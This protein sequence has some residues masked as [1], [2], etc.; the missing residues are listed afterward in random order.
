MAAGNNTP[1]QLYH[2]NTSGSVPTSANLIIGELAINVPDGKIFYKD[3]SN[4]VNVIATTS[5]VLGFFPRIT[6]SGDSTEQYTAAAPY[7]FSNA[8]FLKANSAYAS[9]NVTGTYANAAYAQAN[10]ATTNAATADSKAVAAGSYANAAFTTANNNTASI[11]DLQGVNLTQNTN[12]SNVNT[13]AGKAFDQA[14][15]NTINITNLQGVD[16]TQN[17]GIS[18]AFLQANSA[19]ALANL[20]ST[21]SALDSFARE[22]ATGAFTQANAAFIVANNAVAN[23][24]TITLAGNL[25]VP[26]YAN[27]NQRLAVGTGAYTIL[28]NLIAQ[29]TGTSDYYSQVNQQNLSGKGTADFVATANNGT[30][31]VNYVDMGIAGGNYDNTTPNAFT[32]VQPND[33]YF[34][35]VGNPSQNYGGNVYFGTAG[36]GSFADIVF[37]QG[38]GLNQTARFR[39]NGNV[40]IYRP[41]VANSFTTSSGINVLTYAQDAN[42]YLQGLISQKVS[43]SGDTMTGA[44]T[45]NAS[46]SAN[47]LVI[48]GNVAISQDLRVSGNLYLGGNATTISSNNLTLSDP[49][50]YLADGNPTD[51]VDIGFVGAY[52]DGTYKH[53]GFARDHSDDKWKLF[54]SVTDEPNTTINWAQATYATLKVGGLES[55]SAIIKGVNLFDY[56]NIIHTHANTA[57]NRAN[58][59]VQS[60]AVIST[61]RLVQSATTGNVTI[62]LATSGVIAGTYTYPQLQ[63]DSYGRV[64]TISN[65]TPVTS[66]NTRTGA[67]TLQLA[68]ITNTLGYTPENANTAAANLALIAGINATQNTDIFNATDIATTARDRLVIVSKDANSASSYANSG[69]MVANAASSYANSGYQQANSAYTLATVAVDNALAGST[70]ANG[71]FIKAN[72]AYE[73]QNVTGTYANSSYQQANSAALYANGA[74]IQANSAYGSQNVTG[75]YANSAYDR[76]N[77]AYILAQGA[78]NTANAGVTAGLAFIQANAAFEQANASY[79]S[80]NVTGTYANSAYTQANLAITNASAGSSYANSAFDKANAA[81]AS[82][83]TTGTYA[84]SAYTRANTA[85]NNA[86]VADAKAVS[87]GSYANSAYEMANNAYTAGGLI[88]GSYANSAFLKANAAYESQNTTGVYANAAFN[89]AN[90]GTLIAQAA[91]DYANSVAIA[92]GFLTTI[93]WNVDTFTGDGSNTQ[94]AL[95]TTPAAANNVTV[96]YNG[97]TLLRSA[98]TL[99]L[100]N[101]V[102]SSP[103]ANGAQIEVTVTRPLVNEGYFSN[104]TNSVVSANEN[105]NGAFRHA[106]A[107]FNQANTTITAAAGASLYANGA[108][109]QANGAFIKANSG[110]E[111]QNTTGT[112]AN[113]AFLKANSA[114]ESQ[115]VTGTYANGAYEVANS[116]SLYANGAFT[117]SNSAYGQANTATG[118]ASVADGKA[119]TAGNYA[120][121]AYTQANTATTNASTADSKAVTA[122]SYANS[123]FTKANTAT[124]DAGGA[125]LYANTAFG[126]ANSASLYANGA[127]TQANT[128]VNNAAGAS[129]YANGAFIQANAA[130]NTVNALSTKVTTSNVASSDVY[131][132][133]LVVS[134]WTT[135]NETTEILAT[136]TGATGTVVHNLNDASIFYH[137]SIAANITANFT[138]VPT[139]ADRSISVALILNQGVNPYYASG[140]QI[141]GVSQT[142]KWLNS[143][144]PALIGNT[145][146]IQTLNL[147]RTGG[148]WIVLG[149]FATYG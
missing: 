130:F 106:N 35:V 28:P 43:K 41:L 138:N 112:Y 80:Q 148:S 101:I 117:Q 38:T 145:V 97:A 12:I 108:F 126:V 24:T 95:S 141:D 17:T 36:S 57:Y 45:I 123:A 119:V 9:Q 61:D 14:N 88:A 48:S 59:T 75:T 2:S 137:S 31:S 114:Y 129:L 23:T 103:P 109:V 21:G 72:S 96:N 8:S 56:A 115:N 42:T 70:Y 6:F 79:A 118:N 128:A 91:Y 84:N 51:L 139:T 83:N 44:L 120:N 68:D 62:D 55:N 90:T 40:E 85:V 4:N 20:L 131:T 104:T 89:K 98:Y 49:L 52:N 18:S 102:F 99:D 65:Q 127:F 3:A 66:F 47:A 54:D 39:Y 146:Q 58:G 87:A 77:S 76:A 1:I 19:Y 5:S 63:V 82:Q 116:A 74:F 71:A 16:A 134:G 136:K 22:V 93:I 53:T 33:G 144:V 125:S 60:L 113:A 143:Q 64:T 149:Q 73:S 92:T 11:T 37:I 100:N 81:Y 46:A 29:F 122:G 147:V 13:F 25:T 15:T 86:A 135:L 105:A 69:F 133:N 94:F 107:A 27:V 34:M 30:D 124:N 121:S 142:V 110:Y 140:I 50:I 111:S 26:G 78:Y 67:V 132:G 7:A 10:T 32:F